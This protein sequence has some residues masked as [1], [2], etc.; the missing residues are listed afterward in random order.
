[1]TDG[2]TTLRELLREYI[3]VVRHK[4]NAGEQRQRRVTLSKAAIPADKQPKTGRE[5]P[6]HLTRVFDVD[7][8]EWRTLINDTVEVLA[9]EKVGV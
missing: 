3:L 9:Y 1:M 7:L 2:E 5:A 4:N 6:A 8:Q